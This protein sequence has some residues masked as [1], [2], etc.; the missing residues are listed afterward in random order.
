MLPP[1][2]MGL[3]SFAFFSR[4]IGV[5]FESDRS[6]IQILRVCPPRYRFHASCH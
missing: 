2:H 5:T 1:I 4:G 6:A 3:K